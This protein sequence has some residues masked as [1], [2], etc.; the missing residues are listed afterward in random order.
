MFGTAMG[1]SAQPRAAAP[2]SITRLHCGGGTVKDFNAFFSDSN[3][4]P[5]G[6]RPLANSCYLI[7]HCLKITRPF[8]G[9]ENIYLLAVDL[10]FSNRNTGRC[11]QAYHVSN[12]AA[13]M[14]KG[15]LSEQRIR[16]TR[17]Y[18]VPSISQRILCIHLPTVPSERINLGPKLKPPSFEISSVTL[19]P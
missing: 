7:R 4:Y 1:A 17:S 5:A 12:V 18:A 2:L 16:N 15:T 13:C 8:R 9:Q 6:P 3:D 11:G 10:R 14:L 19:P